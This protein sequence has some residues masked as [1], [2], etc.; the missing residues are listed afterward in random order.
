MSNEEEE[1]PVG[2]Q[3]IA[4]EAH[5]PEQ[6]SA[7]IAESPGG[8]DELR[9]YSKDIT[10]ATLARKLHPGNLLARIVLALLFLPGFFLSV[11]PQGRAATRA[12]LLLPKFITA[13]Q[14]APLTLVDE[15][16]QHTQQSISS[17]SGSVFLDIYAPTT[18][19]PPVPGAREGMV[20]IPGVGDNRRDPQLINFS[21]SLAHAGVI[22]M[23]MTTPTLLNF[24]LSVQDTDA[25]V[26]AFKTLARWPG[27]GPQR[28]GIVGFSAGDA[29]ACFAAADPRIRNQVAFIANFGGYFNA[30]TLLQDVGRRALK[31]NGH[32]QPWQPQYVP[33]QVLAGVIAHLLPPYEGSRLVR[34]FTR[35]GTPLTSYELASFST[36]TVAAYHLLAGDEPGQVDR[37]LAALSP[38]LHALLSQLSPSRVIN[39]I[40]APIYLL[41]DRSDQYV[42]FTESRAFAAALAGIR[43][44]YDFAEFGIFQHVEVP[45]GLGL[46][47]VLG[48]GLNLFRILNEVLLPGS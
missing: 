39:E 19:A 34:S 20:V 23:D 38:P 32:L 10:P 18:P 46:D 28:I 3:F 8:R 5:P 11:L 45:A 6:P 14:P 29:L 40:R 35:G 1:P 2:A 27:V 15:P 41:H 42:P 4:P 26:Q 48:D 24:D 9:S 22:V 37:N 13:S 31:V 25:V 30:F 12:L 33:L 21:Q 7:R 47:Q 43:H 16:I 17:T 36:D 44:P